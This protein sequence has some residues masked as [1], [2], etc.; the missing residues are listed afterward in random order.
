MPILERTTTCWNVRHVV[1]LHINTVFLTTLVQPNT[2]NKLIITFLYYL[3]EL[4]IYIFF[5]FSPVA[6]VWCSNQAIFTL[7]RDT[8][9]TNQIRRYIYLYV[10]IEISDC[11]L[12]S[13]QQ[14]ISYIMARTRYLRSDDNDIDKPTRLVGFLQCY[15]NETKVCGWISR[16][17]RT[18]YS[19]SGPTNLRCCSLLLRA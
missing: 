11:S 19:D 14:F 4:K 1:T 17:N 10:W 18:H 16:S 9:Y 3:I 8:L 7:S 5:L 2:Y 12:I 15:F 13:T 6:I